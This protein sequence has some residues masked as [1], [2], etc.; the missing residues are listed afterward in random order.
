MHGL[1]TRLLNFHSHKNAHKLHEI[2]RKVVDK[3]TETVCGSKA[4]ESFQSETGTARV[5]HCVSIV[6]GQK[7]SLKQPGSI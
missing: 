3:R 1:A 6:A 5:L 2:S 7:T 4:S